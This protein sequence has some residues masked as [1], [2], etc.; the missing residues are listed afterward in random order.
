MLIDKLIIY[1]WNVFSSEDEEAIKSAKSA[2]EN[3]LESECL[4][5]QSIILDLWKAAHLP[6]V[7]TQSTK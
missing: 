5:L 2:S 6:D 1:S 4:L 7:Q 3:R